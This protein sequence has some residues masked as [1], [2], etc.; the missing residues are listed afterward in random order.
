LPKTYEKWCDDFVGHIVNDLNLC[1]W[2]FHITYDDP[3]PD[4]DE[5]CL[6]WTQVDSRYLTAYI[7]FTPLHHDHWKNKR[8]QTAAFTII[9]EIVHILVD[10]LHKFAMKSTSELTHPHLVDLVEQSVQRI[11]RIVMK[12]TSRKLLSV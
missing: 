8:Y 3:D 10:P 1:D 5:N 9:H 2:G 12:H 4:G 7:H 6:A 11:S